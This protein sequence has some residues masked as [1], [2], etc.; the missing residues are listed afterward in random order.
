MRKKKERIFF[1]FCFSTCLATESTNYFTTWSGFDAH[2]TTSIDG[3]CFKSKLSQRMRSN[4][5]WMLLAFTT[6]LNK[7]N[8]FELRQEEEST[9]QMNF[10]MLMVNIV[11]SWGE[12]KKG[13]NADGVKTN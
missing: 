2:E 4:E 8:F 9:G 12:E 3:S 13:R 1:T 7:D 10:I 5:A 6:N 11:L